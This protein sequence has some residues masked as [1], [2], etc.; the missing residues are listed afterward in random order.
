MK[1]KNI[2]CKKLIKR[3]AAALISCVCVVSC[4]MVSAY[5]DGNIDLANVITETQ[6][7]P[8]EG[9]T[10][11]WLTVKPSDGEVGVRI[12][13]NDGKEIIAVDNYGGIYING[14]I[15]ANGKIVSNGEEITSADSNNTESAKQTGFFDPR[16][17]FLYLGLV[18]NL[19]F[20]ICL[21]VKVHG[22]SQKK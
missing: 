5:A 19:I 21:A 20:L 22:Y 17:G 18:I 9:D 15:Y 13:S 1:G 14:D 11:T 10:S 4:F 8:D 16:D 2:M 12:V 7:N 6:R 3:L